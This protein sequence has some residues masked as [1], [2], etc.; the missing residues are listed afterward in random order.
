MGNRRFAESKFGNMERPKG[1]AKRIDHLGIVATAIKQLGIIEFFDKKIPKLS[2][3]N[4][5]VGQVVAAMILIGLGYVQRVLYITP[6]FLRGWCLERLIGPGVTS[7]NFNDEIIGRALDAIF[8]AGSTELFLELVL[9]ILP[10]VTLGEDVR[11]HHGSA[12]L[13]HRSVL[14]LKLPP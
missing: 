13:P 14:L 5:T 11:F 8:E 7:E 2:H 4:V 9:S 1:R 10:L 12:L 3:H 6:Q